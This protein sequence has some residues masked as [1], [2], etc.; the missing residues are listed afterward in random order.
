MD[1]CSSSRGLTLTNHSS[2]DLYQA[3]FL[4]VSLLWAHLALVYG[5]MVT[6]EAVVRIESP[7]RNKSQTILHYNQ[8]C[9]PGGNLASSLSFLNWKMR[10]LRVFTS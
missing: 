4:G 8:L 2:L 6:K 10:L 1:S 9:L 3:V 5:G 7:S